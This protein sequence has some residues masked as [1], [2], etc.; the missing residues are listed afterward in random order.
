MNIKEL[1]M[2]EFL[3]T[4][5][6]WWHWVV[7]GIALAVSEIVVPLFVVIWFGLSA[8]AVGFIDLALKTTFFVELSI[9]ILLSI[10]LLSVWFI[11]FR[12]KDVDR[13]GQADE[14]F[15]TVGVVIEAISKNSR[16]EVQ[17]QSP[18]LGS[19]RWLASSDEDI[20][21]G[22]KVKIVDVKGQLIKVREDR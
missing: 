22:T 15:D 14:G 13:S 7:F 5:L 10:L 11:Y 8:I 3:T 16:G 4:Q 1:F 2:I 12:D 20:D 19:S 21:V 18:V 6:L 9:W 17:F